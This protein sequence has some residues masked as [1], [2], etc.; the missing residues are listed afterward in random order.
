MSYNFLKYLLSNYTL[1][2]RN[3]RVG[4]ANS[5]IQGSLESEE[6][7]KSENQINLDRQ[8]RAL[9]D[10]FRDTGGKI[11][12]LRVLRSAM[13][14][15]DEIDRAVRGQDN[16]NQY[17]GWRQ[18]N[19]FYAEGTED[20]F[21]NIPTG[22]SPLVLQAPKIPKGMSVQ[23]IPDDTPLTIEYQANRRSNLKQIGRTLDQIEKTERERLENR[24]IENESIISEGS[25]TIS[26]EII[27]PNNV[28]TYRPQISSDLKVGLYQPFE[29]KDKS[30][31][32]ERILKFE[33]EI[34]EKRPDL[35]YK[36][37]NA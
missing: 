3:L 19:R 23:E 1:N 34:T 25:L 30:E 24:K 10:F 8:K 2:Q 35:D 14:L 17:I 20:L 15:S 28:N 31:I 5:S 6:R 13:F 9:Q 11:T 32:K 26:K 29:P 12:D 7:K 18:Y 37:E 27:V 4:A 16:P 22:R 33:G 21:T 36:F